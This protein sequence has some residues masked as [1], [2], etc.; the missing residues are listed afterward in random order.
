M[1][2]QITGMVIIMGKNKLIEIKDDKMCGICYLISSTNPNVKYHLIDEGT[3]YTPK[4]LF[5]CEHC[6]K[7]IEETK[8]KCKEQLKN[9]KNDILK[10]IAFW[11]DPKCSGDS[12]V[13]IR[14][15]EKVS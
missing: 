15:E 4:D 12:A 3:F 13:D 11:H 8:V 5:V 10:D 1:L 2:M 7:W 9:P 14:E 6:R